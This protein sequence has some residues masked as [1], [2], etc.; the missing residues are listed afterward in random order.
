[1]SALQ[2][3]SGN[4]LLAALPT[5]DY[6]RLQPHLE[7]V[8]LPLRQ[9]IY[10]EGERITNVYFPRRAIISLVTTLED[11]SMMEAGLVGHEG[12]AGIPLLLGG[13]TKVHRSFVQMAGEAWRLKA[14]VLQAEFDRGGALQKL[15]LRY[16]Q[17]LFTQI[18]QTG[19]CNRFHTTEER[20][21]RWLLLV[22]DCIS[23]DE[24][25]LTQEFISQ[26]IGVRRAGVTVAAGALSQAGLIR[27]TRGHISIVDREGLENFSCECYGMVQ[28]EFNWLYDFDVT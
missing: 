21:A 5:A 14:T 27:Y 9:P 10:N 2:D 13:M 15:L 19:V 26:M 28:E 23:S 25:P 3:P 11:G 24:F 16:L 8:T 1:M 12:M 6:Q 20:L 17:S 7:L 4:R 22:A 18:A